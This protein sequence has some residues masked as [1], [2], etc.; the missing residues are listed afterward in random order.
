M[1]IYCFDLDGTLCTNTEGKYLEA[2]P[3]SERIKKVNS[4]FNQGNQIV[5]FTARGTVTGIDW[6]EVTL[7]QLYLWEVK[8]HELK[9]GKPFAHFYIDDRAINDEDFFNEK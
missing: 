7:K 4:L 5:I 1:K 9:L 3:L 2:E 8:Y 6:R